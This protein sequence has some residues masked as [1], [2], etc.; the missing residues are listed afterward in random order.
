M[1]KKRISVWIVILCLLVAG[2][3]LI[4]VDNPVV[5]VRSET[6]RLQWSAVL[7]IGCLIFLF[8]D[9]VGEL[10]IRM[11][12]ARDFIALMGQKLGA[13]WTFSNG[14]NVVS[15]AEDP[16][17]VPELRAHL[18][19][20]YGFFWRRKIRLLL[21]VGESEQIEAI[22]PGLSEQRWLEGQNTVLLWAGSI[23]GEAQDA[24]LLQWR[25]LCRNCAL[26]GVVW[27]LNKE[28]S[29]N[30]SAMNDSVRRL[31]SLA[32]TLRCQLLLHVWQVCDSMWPQH[33]CEIGAIGC[34]LPVPLSPVRLA[35]HLGM[36]AQPLREQGLSQLQKD[37]DHDFLLRLS[38]DVATDGVSGWCA[39]LSALFRRR[40]VWL[41]GVWFSL[42]L[43]LQN[44][45]RVDHH[46]PED[47]AWSGIL[48]DRS[49]RT[50]R[51]GW[52]PARV[53]YVSALGLAFIWGIG[54]L[55]SFASN[56]AEVGQIA[57][58][59]SALQQP[60]AGTDTK[61]ALGELVRE[62]S[63]LDYRSEHGA[64]WYQRFGLN[65]SH[66]L[67]EAVWPLYM[68]ANNQL[69]RDPAVSELEKRLK[70][71]V[72]LPLASPLRATRAQQAYNYLKAYLML[73]RPEKADAV[74][75][76]ETLGAAEPALWTFY[77]QHL[78]EHPDWAIKADLRL[79]AQTRQVLLRELGQRNA[80]SSLYQHVL[81]TAAN[82]Y[83]PMALQQMVGDTDATALFTSTG[84]V[85]GAFTRE[86]W[87]GQVRMAIDDAANAR[88]EEIDWVL[89]D[90]VGDVADELS[91]EQL[92]ARLTAR[93][94]RDYS[95]A[96]LAFLN[97]LRWQQSTS[98][99]D[100]TAQ[101]TLMSDARQS[102]LIAL[103]NTLSY[104]GQAGVRGQALADSLIESAQKLVGQK[105]PP[106]VDQLA[107]APS[108]PL[109]STFGPLMALLGKA[110]EGRASSDHLSLQAFLT[111]VTSVRLKLQQITNAPDPQAMTQVLAQTVFQGKG[112]D[113]TDAQAY[114]SLIAASLGAE[115][116]P[117]A[118]ALFVQPLTQAWQQILQPSSAGLNRDWQR[119]I[120]DEW[121]GAFD[122]RYPFAASS[123]DA[124]LP[125]LGQ[126]I[127]ADSGRIEQFLHQ[128]LNGLV[129]KE[130]SRWVIDP[131]QSQGL[132]FNPAFL[133]AINH[134]SQLADVLYTDGGMGMSFELRGKPV[135]DVVQTRFV[136]NGEQ[137]HYFNQRER[138]Q[139]FSW[140]G[141]G[142]HPGISLTWT[143]IHGG[144]RL[145]ADYQGTWGL[146][147]LLEEATVTPLD[148]GDSRFRVV[149]SAPDGLGL[150]W[151]LRTELADGPLTLLKLRGF[152][153][154]RDIF[155]VGDARFAHNGGPQ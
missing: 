127:R 69:L 76:A 94:F 60:V 148:D 126:M 62:L 48:N 114:G 10:A 29:N 75:L 72:N 36:L 129:R 135:Q 34:M 132:R 83:A 125:M 84:H 3:V 120:V 45:L 6:A 58:A 138:W 63:R 19:G 101:L 27:V 131:R 95:S 153:L 49:A 122:N 13:N 115:W 121:H 23:Q 67:R 22:A 96:W 109:D 130:G 86:A 15:N 102:P 110:P 74:F 91:P 21:V 92:K 53:A 5:Q 143:G 78:P 81:D 42:P 55:L 66:D 90:N 146:I 85:P 152:R 44:N 124:S 30:V 145:Y 14:S 17:G 88:R 82:H 33:A 50:Q 71:L 70:A 117:V 105:A 25:G 144:E 47:P 24:L 57:A 39:A 4:W 119:A 79:I 56:R 118:H 54:L 46:W 111:R 26:N 40:D 1:K 150:T 9:G 52:H 103:M 100:V 97:S 149:L 107:Q 147:R 16:F 87:E 142:D 64:P 151:H 108:G 77:G 11:L 18:K 112:V 43:R 89:S 59:Y 113:L 155:L 154:P 12:G 38:R 134:L 8:L 61:Q 137:H 141:Q 128:Q 98:L 28:Q 116:G 68:Q 32:K 41:R 136:L 139:R 99:H 37:S 80:E 140:P 7:L 133:E 20:R 73:A 51:L 65:R 106:M 123:S 104:Q 93:Y 2:G 31:Q 35:D